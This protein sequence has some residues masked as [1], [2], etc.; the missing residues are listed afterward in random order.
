MKKKRKFSEI[1]LYILFIYKRV[2]GVYATIFI[3]FVL[4]T[5]DRMT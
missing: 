2:V 5:V 1:F 4:F 3:Y